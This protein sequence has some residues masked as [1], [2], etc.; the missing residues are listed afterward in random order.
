MRGLKRCVVHR[1]KQS[2]DQAAKLSMQVVDAMPRLKVRPGVAQL[3]IALHLPAA[4]TQVQQLGSS[5]ELHAHCQV[6]R[7]TQ[8]V[9]AKPA[10]TS[11]VLLGVALSQ[12]I[13]CRSSSAGSRKGQSQ[14]G[15]SSVV[16]WACETQA[17]CPC[18]SCALLPCLRT[19]SSQPRMQRLTQ[20]LWPT[21]QVGPCSLHLNPGGLL[22]PACT[23]SVRQLLPSGNF[24]AAAGALWPA[25]TCT[26]VPAAAAAS[27]TRVLTPS[28]VLQVLR[29]RL[30][31]TLQML[32]M[33][34]A[35]R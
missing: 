4:C 21:W 1:R 32:C 16:A 19:C 28:G 26:A 15:S 24:T 30:A 2:D 6:A 20:T 34:T 3:C 27:G 8:L 29:R 31:R 5:T 33:W 25:D 11:I 13:S 35:T 17:P 22:D 18:R 14:R 9:R 12:P 23:C 10:S 7:H